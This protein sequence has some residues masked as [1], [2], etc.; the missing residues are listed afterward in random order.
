MS[1]L[2]YK[3]DK[4]MNCLAMSLNLLYCRMV[5]GVLGSGRDL[6]AAHHCWDVFGPAVDLWL[7]SIFNDPG[8]VVCT[9]LASGSIKL[10]PCC[11]I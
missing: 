7:E 8:P 5:V 6:R 3:T 1:T 11:V 2:H 4:R 10:G 9:L